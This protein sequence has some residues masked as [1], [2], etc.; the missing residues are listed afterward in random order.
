MPTPYQ[1]EL[2]VARPFRPG[3][4]FSAPG[5]SQDFDIVKRVDVPGASPLPSFTPNVYILVISM[6]MGP[7]FP[8]MATDPTAL[9]GSGDTARNCQSQSSEGKGSIRTG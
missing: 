7:L 4:L 5:T 9:E 2:S 6:R 3:V 1:S 8:A